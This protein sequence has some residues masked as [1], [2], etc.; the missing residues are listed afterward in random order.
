MPTVSID[1]DASG[2]I[3]A[4]AEA[5]GAIDA[6]HGKSV[7]VDI[8][9]RQH[10]GAGGMGEA[11]QGMRDFGTA[12]DR[13]GRSARGM[14]DDLGRSAGHARNMGD[15]MG[16]ASDHMSRMADDG[17]RLANHMAAVDS[18]M[19]GGAPDSTA[20]GS[21]LRQMAIDAALVTGAIAGIGAVSSRS[22]GAVE[23]GSSRAGQGLREI[24][25]GAQA[26]HE[27]VTRLADTMR[28][29]AATF[30][31]ASSGRIGGDAGQASRL[32][33]GDQTG[34]KASTFAVDSAGNVSSRLA[35]ASTE[36]E[37]FSGSAAGMG[38]ALGS[39]GKEMERFSGQTSEME[40]H[41]GS[42]GRVIDATG[43]AINGAGGSGGGGGL[44]GLIS[45]LGGLPDVAMPSAMALKA[46]GLTAG[47]SAL[48]MGALS[49]AVA[50]VGLAGV[51]EDFAHN[52]QLMHAGSEAV[53]GFNREFSAMRGATSAAGGPAMAGVAASMKGVGHELAAIG[54]ANIAPVLNS[55]ASLGNQTTQAMRKLAPSIGPAV[56]GL[57]ALAGAVIGA[58]GDSGPAVTSFANKV[59]QNAAGLQSL[60]SSVIDTAGAVG[61]ATVDALG[62]M[63]QFD[64]GVGSPSG[65]P[66]GSKVDTSS[67]PTM[68]GGL[69][70][71]FMSAMGGPLVPMLLALGAGIDVAHG[72]APGNGAGPSKGAAGGFDPSKPFSGMLPD[73]QGG[74]TS[75]T[76]D[77]GAAKPS[78]PKASRGPAGDFGKGIGAPPLGNVGSPDAGQ[79]SGMTAG[80]IMTQ[81]RANSG[82]PPVGQPQ[83]SGVGPRGAGQSVG[84]MP[85][86]VAAGLGGG[87]I[88][89]FND[90]MRSAQGQIAGGGGATGTAVAQH[91]QKAV[92]VAAPAA[93]AG[94]GAIGGA[95]NAGMAA[96]STST[97]SVIDTVVIKHSKHIIDLAS[98]ALGVHSPSTEF[99]YLGR[100]T[101]RGFGQGVERDSH[102]TFGAMDNML[103]GA[104]DMASKFS[105]GYDG[106]VPAVITVR[107]KAEEPA[108]PSQDP[109]NPLLSTS[110]TSMAPP[111]NHYGVA[112][113]SNIQAHNDRA[114]G[115]AQGR[116]D[117]H[118]KAMANLG[119]INPATGQK[120]QDPTKADSNPFAGKLGDP[121]GP[122]GASYKAP[123][124]KQRAGNLWDNLNQHGPQ[125][126]DG[127]WAG[128]KKAVDTSQAPR[129]GGPGSAGGGRAMPPRIA[130]GL[131]L[132]SLGKDL[133]GHMHKAGQ[134]SAQGLSQ[135]MTA[136]VGKVQAAG[137]HL[138]GAGHAGY[139][140]KDKQHSPSAE[141]AGMA[142]NSVAGAVG[143]MSAG[144]PALAAAGAGAAAAM[145]AA[146][147]GPMA[148]AGLMVGYTWAQNVETG[149]ST[150]IKKADYQSLGIPA[151]LGQAGLL[152]LAKTGLLSAGSGAQS[153]KTPGNAPGVVSLP[154]PQ[155]V[156]IVMQPQHVVIDGQ[157]I[158]TIT[159]QQFSGFLDQM[160][161]AISLQPSA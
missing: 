145:Q 43:R 11:T 89:P 75:G 120:W 6:L 121:F 160:T 82:L 133:N 31:V 92:N 4:C 98:A 78:A 58:F 79:F 81:Q 107:R 94:G 135:G 41:V 37:R 51:A 104:Q 55:A 96:G 154:A 93:A 8:N 69:Q 63:G 77:G 83:Y 140:K 64:S 129:V 28:K 52:N 146:T 15:H 12:A 117:L 7:N 87:G 32:G 85:A 56:Q 61:G 153:Y 71:A 13:A 128:A 159:Q 122:G 112:G 1:G 40:R 36:M 9:V 23:S 108:D 74:F 27:Q 125:D 65:K 2:A 26:S 34:Q 131:G 35:G 46:V 19:R 139:K 123:S 114:A 143:G 111:V 3:A 47:V 66:P 68:G 155:P 136:H 20:R 124:L 10:G 50:G 53:R 97:Q 25:S 102:H 73:G 100:M 70:G 142:G 18:I 24:G 118:A 67:R 156:T 80:Q 149:V 95:M 141:W 5:Q 157:V 115:L 72:G 49:A 22:L 161:G 106:S 90:M 99:D 29:S 38:S 109:S 57:T 147:A 42:A 134:A 148:D 44:G 152:G 130:A 88:A 144:I 137:S 48:G 110:S 127:P 150:Q 45:K 76:G 158:A 14:G 91:I 119:V 59:T 126:K 132:D 30:S 101:S 86:S 84:A 105:P 17:Q 54:A 21:G 116:A 62:G 16:R 33:G 113:M 151:G 138:A 103:T 39:S 60:T